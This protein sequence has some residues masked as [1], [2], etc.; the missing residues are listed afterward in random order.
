MRETNQC[1]IDEMFAKTSQVKMNEKTREN[2]CLELV[3]I[4][5]R[6][7]KLMND[8]GFKKI[9]NP[10]L[11]DM[12][13]NFTVKAENI[14]EKIGEKTNDVRYRIKLAVEGE[15]VSLKAD[16]ATCRGRSILGVNSQ[17]I[18]VGKI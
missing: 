2:A 17:F 12:R 9:L 10:L 15:L 6:P 16:V 4:N 7:L 11:E 14:L 1:A 18:S 5:D 3:T 13:A 8:S